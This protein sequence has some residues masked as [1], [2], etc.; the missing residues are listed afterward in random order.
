MI[1]LRLS[2]QTAAP[3]RLAIFTDTPEAMSALDALTVDLSKN[4][5]FHLLER[6]E[7][8][9]V[10]REQGMS[11]ANR[12]DLKLGRLLG[13]DGLMILDVVR[14]SRA[15]N[16]MARLIAVK[17][18]VVLT[19]GSFPWPL[20][21]LFQWS[22]SVGT[23]IESFIPKLSLLPR[24]AIPISVVNLRSAIAN[25]EGLEFERQLKL[26]AIQRLSQ[27]R[28]FFVLER[29]K[30][31]LLSA[32]KN[33]KA[34]E[35]AFWNGAYLLD[36]VVD[37]NGV[38]K[39]TITINARLMPA[40]GGEPVLIEARGSRTNLSEVI[41][42][43]A[44]KI[45]TALK[46]SPTVK[47]WN[48]SDEAAKYFDEALWASR[49]GV[50]KE[51]EAA[52]DSAWALGKQ[53]LAGA[54]VR[55]KAYLAEVDSLS[56]NYGR[57]SSTLSPGYNS[58]GKPNGPPPSDARVQAEVRNLHAKYPSLVAY[59]IADMDCERSIS[60]AFADRSPAI[61]SIDGILHALD[62]YYAFSRNSPE[63]V[64]AVLRSGKG[65]NDW[66]N[67][68]W[69][70]LGVDGLV[71]ASKVLQ[72]F[73]F[74]PAARTAASEK[75]AVLRER[76][77]Q[78][79]GLI[80]DSQS[81]H[82]SYYVGP[83]LATHDELEHSI[84]ETPNL[85]SCML[86]WGCF[87]QEKPE[88]CVK[89]YRKLMDSPVFCYLHH[90]FWMRD[91][92]QPRIAVWNIEAPGHTAMVWQNFCDE[93]TGSTNLL[94]RLE[95]QALALAKLHDD[96]K[97]GIGFTNFF[98]EIFKNR[99]ALVSNPVEVMG[100][101]DGPLLLRSATPEGITSESRQSLERAYYSTFIKELT[102]MEQEYWRVTVPAH[103]D[104]QKVNRSLNQGHP[105]NTA[106]AL[107][108]T[109]VFEQQK[110]YLKNNRPYEFFEFVKLFRR[111]DYTRQQAIE[112]LPLIVGYR[113]NLVAQSQSSSGS[114]NATLKNALA[115]VNRLENDVSRILDPSIPQL[116]PSQP[117][118]LPG[119]PV[120]ETRK[121]G[122]GAASV[123]VPET[124]GNIIVVKK[125]L[126]IPSPGVPI[127]QFST[128]QYDL[129]NGQSTSLLAL[130]HQWLEGRLVLD[131]YYSYGEAYATV[132]GRV[133]EH[134]WHVDD[135]PVIAI[136]DPQTESWQVIRCPK[137]TRENRNHFYHRTA[138]L[139]GKV[140]TSSAGKVWAYD[141][142]SKLWRN[143]GIP[144]VGQCQLFAVNDRL[145]A[146]TGNIIME[147]QDHGGPARILASNRRH[148]AAS[149]LDAEDFGTPTLFS[150]PGH[151]LRA[152]LANKIA[153]WDGNDWHVICSAPKAPLPAVVSDHGAMFMADG[154]NSPAGIWRMPKEGTHLENCLDREDQPDIVRLGA[155]S[156]NTLKATWNLPS[157]YTLPA[158]AAADRG[159]DLFLMY[160][161]SKVQDLMDQKQ[162]F[163]VSRKFLP[164]N[165]Y[166]SVV[167]AFINGHD[168]PIKLFFKFNDYEGVAPPLMGI[169]TW[170]DRATRQVNS[171]MLF[172]QR[173][174]YLG[175]EF[176]GFIYP[177]SGD[178]YLPKPG[179]WVLSLEQVDAEIARGG[180]SS[181]KK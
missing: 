35:S 54:M 124:A 176:F 40:K 168:D 92:L 32:E 113:S 76:V 179:V 93:L 57:G 31:Q 26:L 151:T 177:P 149:A 172:D 116:P 164:Q 165:N 118:P 82:D 61:A 139:H 178:S 17:P 53:D 13:A 74:A 47:E 99:Y 166:H 142:P 2:A 126:E 181:L 63:G 156:E 6:A 89:L 143:L 44:I 94:W 60:Y 107:Q 37:Q 51:A 163:V 73:Y 10:Y 101:W 81:V 96:V 123:P 147:I 109:N 173:K 39:D 84:K 42:A 158:I 28:Q 78:V 108:A 62:L 153:E 122:R 5:R 34:D 14:T 64:P 38:S 146:A 129:G 43:L 45:V 65:E 133:T 66:H 97:L 69:Y 145:Y 98:N 152:A 46:A 52:A 24:D 102:A 134:G 15:T 138:L 11:A 130:T 16:L 95:A 48:A 87:W 79:A 72:G 12:D 161:R 110:I 144:E 20:K 160:D 117:S 9:K 3:V 100:N 131:M 125:F 36:G 58:A 80:S 8:E 155:G 140:F 111:K 119:R 162:N 171:W 88:D 19:D 115:R 141:P 175:R 86:D 167:L 121:I 25:Q 159:S 154:W 67:S 120:F 170:D 49:W 41:N 128:Q 4:D 1:G 157:G 105:D 174:L 106:S 59:S 71:A 22:Y 56:V 30:M 77:R 18:G 75:L 104:I 169:K 33:L 23:Y 148:P 180:I 112:I 150:G 70:Q 83:R 55:I 68:E 29:Q 127:G 137:E 7:I 103:Q 132:K 27:E 91:L 90:K 85:Y 136:L 50:F 21:G 135:Y 114:Q